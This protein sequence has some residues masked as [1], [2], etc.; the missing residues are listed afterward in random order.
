MSRRTLLLL[1]AVGTSV[2]L[3]SCGPPSDDQLIHVFA[4]SGKTFNAVR[5]RA[6]TFN[7][8]QT[9]GDSYTDPGLS[10]DDEE[11]FKGQMSQIKVTSLHVHGAGAGCALTLDV[12]AD[13]FAGTPANYKGYYYGKLDVESGDQPTNIVKTL[14]HPRS[15]SQNTFLYRPLG[16]GWWLEY[17]AYP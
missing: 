6:C 15:E 8:F 13:G 16:G 3:G 1:A 17:L 9:I 4:S 7:H 14:D 11:W 2:S 10:V 5:S 12:W